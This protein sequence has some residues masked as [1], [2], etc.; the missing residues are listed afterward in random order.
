MKPVE[1][2]TH[3][4]IGREQ[5]LVRVILLFPAIVVLFSILAVSASEEC[6]SLYDYD[7]STP[8]QFSQQLISE[9]EDLLEYRL[10][11]HSA[12]DEIVPTLLSIPKR[13]GGPFPVIILLHGYGGDKDDLMEAARPLAKRGYAAAAIDAQYHGERRQEGRNM[14]STDANETVS[15][16]V[17]SVVDVRR[18]IDHLEVRDDVDGSRIGL[19]GGSMGGLLGAIATGIE[20]RIDVPVLIV[21]GGNMR[22]MVGESQLSRVEEIRAEFERTGRRVEEEAEK[23]RCIDPINFVHLISPRPLL[24]INGLHDDIVPVASN[25]ALYA[26]AREPKKIVWYDTGHD[27]PSDEAAR[28]AFFWFEKHL[29][30]RF[31][32]QNWFYATITI[33]VAAS[34]ISYLCLGRWRSE[35]ASIA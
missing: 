34:I 9:D 5:S 11:I 7:D 8:P 23:L 29:K 10:G 4:S 32:L 26:Q 3:F 22:I 13:K 16:F 20:E 17:Q 2:I 12:N 14:Y 30:R 24:M 21:A 33:I 35:Q 27:V 25:R 28:K 6:L 15:A 1:P 31:Y 19:V 18:L